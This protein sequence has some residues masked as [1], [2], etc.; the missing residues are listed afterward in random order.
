MSLF[1]YDQLVTELPRLMKLDPLPIEVVVFE[2]PDCEVMIRACRGSKRDVDNAVR[3][4]VEAFRSDRTGGDPRF[5]P[6]ASMAL[7]EPIDRTEFVRLLSDYGGWP[8]RALPRFV[9]D[10][11]GFQSGLRM[12]AD[13]NDVA[14]M[15][16]L[17]DAFVAFFWSTSA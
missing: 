15:A 7:C 2:E 1:T 8:T 3:F 12:C 5:I 14:A 9:T 6:P 4:W 10:L 16:E 11:D 17:T 13:W